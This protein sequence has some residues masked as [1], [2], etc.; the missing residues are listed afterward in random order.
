MTKDLNQIFGKL[1][2][3]AFP[4]SHAESLY[5][6][7]LH[8][9]ASTLLS[10]LVLP[11]VKWLEHRDFALE[12]YNGVSHADCE[13][14]FSRA[15]YVYGPIRISTVPSSPVWELLVKPT[16][17]LDFV[18]DKTA[19]FFIRDPRDILVSAYYS[20]GYSHPLSKVDA[21]RKIEEHNRSLITSMKL[22]EYAISFAHK[23]VKD[24]ETIYQM[25]Q[26]C[27]NCTILRYEDMINNFS[28]FDRQLRQFINIESK[29]IEKIYSQSRPRRQEDPRSHR[30][31]GQ[32]GGFRQK[33]TQPTVEALNLVL[34]E[35]LSRFGYLF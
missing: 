5:F 16:T 35:T 10:R 11:N 20:F 26:N 28:A 3:F 17:S 19:I 7:S 29:I 2:N 24:F 34:E 25:T 8:K 9:S 32:V 22:D 23:Q 30:R 6:Y 14:K 12:I 31:S 4:L 33:L 15:G 21:I 18:K 13:I 27:K 1:R